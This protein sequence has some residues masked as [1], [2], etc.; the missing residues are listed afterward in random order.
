MKGG[1]ALFRAG[2]ATVSIVVIL[3]IL[4]SFL[5]HRGGGDFVGDRQRVL[6]KES[7]RHA[8]L[9]EKLREATSSAFVE[10]EARNKLGLVRPGET[11]VLVNSEIK[12]ASDAARPEVFSSH[13]TA[14]WNLFF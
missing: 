4:Q 3:G 8:A 1:R 9:L 13:V 11:I 7:R 10:Q 12:N 6:E 2:I 14:W 5:T